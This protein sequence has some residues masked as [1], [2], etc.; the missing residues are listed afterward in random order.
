VADVARNPRGE[1]IGSLGF[2]EQGLDDVQLSQITLKDGT[3]TLVSKESI[4]ILEGKLSPD[5]HSV[6]GNFVCGCLR[7][8]PVPLRLKR[9]AEPAVKL[10]AP[11]GPLGAEFAGTW[12]AKVKL[13]ASWEDGT[14]LPDKTVRVRLTREGAGIFVNTSDPK[15]ELPLSTIVR[16]DGKPAFEVRGAGAVFTGGELHGRE[17][18]GTWSELNSDPVTLTFTRIAQ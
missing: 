12:E 6:E 16:K 11:G 14:A 5:D 7:N 10:P 4:M 18:S 3:L 2:P 9:T 15:A 13:S 1:W 17:L 8:V